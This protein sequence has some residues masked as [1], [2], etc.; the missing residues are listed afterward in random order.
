LE[1]EYINRT[2]KF[3]DRQAW[4]IY[5]S[6]KTQSKMIILDQMLINT[7][8]LFYSHKNYNCPMRTL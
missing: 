1:Y 4:H 3:N 5:S 8:T 6:K 7:Q 2:Q